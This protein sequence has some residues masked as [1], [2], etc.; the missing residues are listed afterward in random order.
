MPAPAEVKR[1][2]DDMLSWIERN[3]KNR[4]MTAV[5]D[6]KAAIR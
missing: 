4:D 3:V 6:P 5:V 1:I 2:W